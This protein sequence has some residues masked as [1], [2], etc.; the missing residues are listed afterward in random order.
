[1]ASTTLD[2]PDPFGPTTT[3]TPG[4]SSIVVASANDLNPLRVRLFKNT[5]AAKLPNRPAQVTDAGVPAEWRHSRCAAGCAARRRC[6][7]RGSEELLRWESTEW[8][9]GS[10]R[11]A[12][13]ELGAIRAKRRSG[14]E[15]VAELR[16][17]APRWR[18]ETFRAQNAWTRRETR[19]TTCFQ[20]SST[21]WPQHRG[22]AHPAHEQGTAPGLRTPSQRTGGRGRRWHHGQ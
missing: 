16:R 4:S 21:H 3:V 8:A 15:T 1:M 2:L 5:A 18:I 22:T 12:A 10:G 9:D 6:G 7:Q 14:R 11:R 13:G 20:S 19:P 17:S